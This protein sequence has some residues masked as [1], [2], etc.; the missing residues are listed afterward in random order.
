MQVPHSKH[1]HQKFLVN[2]SQKISTSSPCKSSAADI[3]FCVYACA[4]NRA[5]N[6]V[7]AHHASKSVLYH[8]FGDE[9]Y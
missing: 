3:F 7:G 1:M 9:T 6:K 2:S 5:I 4:L 8:L